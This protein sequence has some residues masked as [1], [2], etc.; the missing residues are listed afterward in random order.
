[1]EYTIYSII[2]VSTTS[3]TCIGH[4][5]S[6]VLIILLMN[7]R[8]GVP[9]MQFCRE[10]VQYN[11]K[12]IIPERPTFLRRTKHNDPFVGCWH[13]RSRPGIRSCV[14]KIKIA[15]R[16]Q[17]ACLREGAIEILRVY[18]PT[19]YV[20]SPSFVIN[21]LLERRAPC[22]RTFK[23]LLGLHCQNKVRTICVGRF[24]ICARS[25]KKKTI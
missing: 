21:L 20:Q 7:H 1:M 19:C 2:C 11:R 16:R 18:L 15:P 3:M 8:S 10:Y 14:L 23:K 4:A 17:L 6:L 12:T 9:Y 25:K 5:Q 24:R 13:D 22:L